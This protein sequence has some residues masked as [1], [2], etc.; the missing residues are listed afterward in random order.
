MSCKAYFGG[1]FPPRVRSGTPVGDSYT[2]LHARIIYRF[3]IDS[4]SDFGCEL[5]VARTQYVQHSVSGL[6]CSYTKS[7]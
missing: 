2:M 3:I 1:S 5:T 4:G 7:Q 6:T